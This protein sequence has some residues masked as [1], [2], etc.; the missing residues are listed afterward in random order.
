MYYAIEIAC[1]LAEVWMTDIFLYYNCHGERKR[2][3]VALPV[4]A[5]FAIGLKALS[6]VGNAFLLR[7]AFVFFAVWI[8]A[9]FLFGTGT[10]NGCLMS[11]IFCLIVTATDVLTSTLFSFLGLDISRQMQLSTLGRGLYLVVDHIV[12]FGIVFAVC[13][14][15]R[16]SQNVLPV[17]LLLPELPC[18]GISIL[19]C[20]LLA[21]QYVRA[22]EDFPPMY[23]I[24]M[25]GLLYSNLLVLYYTDQLYVQTA[26]RQNLEIAAH[27][28]AMQQEYYE[29][30]CE[31][32]EETR[33]LWHDMKK[34]IRA[35]R[36]EQ[37]SEA[38]GDGKNNSENMTESSQS[39][40]NASLLA[41]E[42]ALESVTPVVDLENRVI[43]VILNEYVQAAGNI[44]A[45]VKMDV[46][47]PDR[48]FVTAADL[49]ILIG[50]TFDNALDACAGL[51][52]GKR[53]ISL[54]L[55][56]QNR[57][58]YYEISNPYPD[59]YLGQHKGHFHGF[60]LKNVR[61]CV[62]R[63][64]GAVDISTE[65]NIFCFMAHLNET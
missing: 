7:I 38:G 53:T 28:Y 59:N 3:K 4:Y 44:G 40:V 21:S 32:Q 45:V 31:R 64:H 41:L 19:L 37:E 34:Y 6:L 13:M 30:L 23:F 49:Y 52:E 9:V 27:H 50:N 11:L 51:P 58:L 24:V 47:V 8:L 20:C 65:G 54:M 60:G 36:A 48:L 29:Q 39:A 55:R 61:Q 15:N 62:E 1:V 26:R 63:Y 22:G 57:V 17:R 12:L 46:Q 25:L 43:S 56:C 2:G 18:W 10:L 42:E 35:I 5:A 16:K 33:A 14:L